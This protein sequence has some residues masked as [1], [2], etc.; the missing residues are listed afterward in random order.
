[1]TAIVGSFCTM[2]TKAPPKLTSIDA[3]LGMK[4]STLLMTTITS[5]FRR[6]WISPGRYSDK[7]SQSVWMTWSK[8]S[9][10]MAWEMRRLILSEAR[11][12]TAETR[13]CPTPTPT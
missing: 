4:V 12:R 1:M 13:I 5:P 3:K 9:S 6:Y 2:T 11:L 7:A 10:R 8:M